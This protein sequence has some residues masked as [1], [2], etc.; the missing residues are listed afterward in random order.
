[1]SKV[2]HVDDLKNFDPYDQSQDNLKKLD[3]M[4][5]IGE[6]VYTKALGMKPNSET[7]ELMRNF[8]RLYGV[9]FCPTYSILGSF[10]SQEFIIT[11]SLTNDPA[12][13]WFCYDRYRLCMYVQVKLVMVWLRQF[14]IFELSLNAIYLKNVN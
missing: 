8:A 11:I 7:I 5:K 14:R 6:E 2:N 3:E 13:N 12:I 9:E 10:A 4:V 1:M